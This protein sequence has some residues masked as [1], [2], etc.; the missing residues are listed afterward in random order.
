MT[1]ALRVLTRGVQQEA[2]PE[3]Y[4]VLSEGRSVG[5]SSRILSLAPFIDKDGVIRVGGRLSNSALPYESRHPMLL[6]RGHVLTDLVVRREHIRNLHSGLQATIS[7]VRRRFWPLAARSVTRKV[8]HGCI[9]CF[10][11]RPVALEALMAD[12]PRNRVTISRP[13]THT[14]VDYAGPILLKE[15]RRRNAKMHKAYISIFMCFS[16]KAVHIKI[17][18]DLTSQAFVASFKRFISRRGKPVCMYSDNG[19]TFVGAQKQLKEFFE[20]INNEQSA[21]NELLRSNEISW[22]F[23]PPHAPHFG[24]LWEAAVKSAKYH[25]QRVVGNAGLTLEEMQTVLCEIEAILNSR[26]LTPLSTDPND[27]SC[28]TPGHFLIGTA[29]N[30]FP[31]PDLTE[32]KENRLLRWQRVEQ[33]RQHFWKRWNSE[34]LHTLI[35]R[36]KWRINKGEQLKVGRLVLIQQSGLGPLQWL[37]GRVLQVHLGVDG[38]ARTATLRT[39]KGC[40][41]RPLTRLAILPLETDESS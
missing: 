38:I 1:A 27:L 17:V 9:V 33:M 3:D 14:G 10:K 5:G 11:C 36:Q 30:R 8:I 29:L 22:N 19:T 6:P 4:R 41:T 13:F 7:A 25:I 37:L 31:V 34:Y 21:V 16:T 15:S 32:E 23:L 20:L 35:E 12:L 26:P 18:S 2:F 40:L 39:S 28:I 24:G